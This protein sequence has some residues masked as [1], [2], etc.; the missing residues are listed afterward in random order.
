MADL[1]LKMK[2]LKSS[3]CKVKTLHRGDKFTVGAS[4]INYSEFFQVSF[5][6]VITLYGIQS[7]VQL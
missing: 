3:E 6:C 4:I 5:A 2:P 1:A 7:T